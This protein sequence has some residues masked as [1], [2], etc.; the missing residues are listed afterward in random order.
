MSTDISE[1]FNTKF[2]E[3]IESLHNDLDIPLEILNTVIDKINTTNNKCKYILKTGARKGCT[4]DKITKQ[5]YCKTHLKYAL[6]TPII[7]D[8]T[9]IHEEE[10]PMIV[11]RKNKYGNFALGN[12][13]LVLKNDK[14]R[15]IIGKQVNSSIVDLTEDDINICKKRKLKYIRDYSNINE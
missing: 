1:Y 2:Y 5:D 4:C 12:T 14:E 15:I 11:F 3:F 7:K 9:T 8:D 10:E 6:E 13:G